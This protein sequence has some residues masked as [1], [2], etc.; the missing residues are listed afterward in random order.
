MQS[1]TLM[2]MVYPVRAIGI[3]PHNNAIN[4]DARELCCARL[5]AD[6]PKSGEEVSFELVDDKKPI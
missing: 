6:S 4:S 1:T 2:S 3:M 5:W